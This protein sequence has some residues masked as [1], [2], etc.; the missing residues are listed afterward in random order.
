MI[1][2]PEHFLEGTS[3]YSGLF[4]PSEKSFS[5]GRVTGPFW[6]PLLCWIFRQLEILV[7]PFLRECVSKYYTT[8]VL[9]CFL[10]Q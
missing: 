1:H 5:L 4:S 3:G 10:D 2:C 7:V 9:V 6:L 8:P